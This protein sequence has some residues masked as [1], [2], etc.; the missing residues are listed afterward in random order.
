ML[1][2]GR[3]NRA[4][5]RLQTRTDLANAEVVSLLKRLAKAQHSTA[6]AQ[7]ASRI[8][9]TI[10]YDTAHG[11][12]PF[13]KVKGLISEMIKKLE[14]AAGADATEKAYCD[15][16]MAKTAEKKSEL[17]GTVSKLSTKLDEASAASAARKQEVK[18]LQADLAALAK[19]QAEMD[20]IRAEQ[21]KAYLQAKADL[22]AGLEG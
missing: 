9:A 11:E 15:E 1:Q 6:L 7:L 3:T 5:S 18:E 19:E 14:A 2:V 12:D 21:N 16:Q 4:G 8:A 10:R 17:E 20:K 13:A 22:A